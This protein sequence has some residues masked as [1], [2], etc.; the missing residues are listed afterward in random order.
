MWNWKTPLSEPPMASD[1]EDDIYGEVVMAPTDIEELEWAL[2]WR[3]KPEDFEAAKRYGWGKHQSL[4]A[5]VR[6]MRRAADSFERSAQYADGQAYY[7][8][9]EEVRQ[10]LDCAARLEAGKS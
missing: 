10:L 2:A 6:A 3:A 4:A 9:M 1:S 8:E 7:K 5:T